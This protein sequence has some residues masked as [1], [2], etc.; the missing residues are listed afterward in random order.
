MYPVLISIVF[1]YFI[2]PFTLVFV[3]IEKIYQT[4]ETVFHPNTSNF[5]KNTPLQLSSRGLEM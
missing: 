1:Y 3:L 2:C 5:I 4:H